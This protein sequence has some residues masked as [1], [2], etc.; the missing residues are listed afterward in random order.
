MVS[1]C[2]PAGSIDAVYSTYSS[3]WMT[4]IVRLVSGDAQGRT[5]PHRSNAL[6]KGRQ[7]LGIVMVQPYPHSSLD[8]WLTRRGLR[9]EVDPI[10]LQ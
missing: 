10:D 1:T 7:G 6:L 8:G 2:R 5:G 9:N 3:T 4:D